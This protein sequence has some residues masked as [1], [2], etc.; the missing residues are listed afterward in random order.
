MPWPSSPTLSSTHS[1]NLAEFYVIGSGSGGSGTGQNR[2]SGGSNYT[3]TL[4][5]DAAYGSDAIGVYG[6]VFGANDAIE[7]GSTLTIPND[8]AYSL[9]IVFSRRS[10]PAAYGTLFQ[11][12]GTTPGMMLRAQV[13]DSGPNSA[14][15][16]HS[17]TF[18]AAYDIASS[19]VDVE[20][21]LVVTHTAG[22]TKLFYTG[23]GASVGLSDRW[24][25][26]G[27]I[28]S[29]FLGLDDALGSNFFPARFRA[30]G[31]WERALSDANA[32]AIA[33][34]PQAE[35]L[36]IP[37]P[38][39]PTGVTAG[40]I[41]AFGA[42]CSWTDASSDETSFDVQYA[43]SPY[44]SWTTASGSPTAANATS[45]AVTGLTDGTAYKFRVRA[46]N[47]NGSSVWVESG[48]FTTLAL[49]RL[50]PN[51]DTTVGSATS[52]GANLFGV[53]D[54]TT[55]DD[56]DYITIPGT[57]TSISLVQGHPSETNIKTWTPSPG[58]SF[59]TST[60]TMTSG[61]ASAITDYAALYVK[62]VTSSTT[63]KMKF[64]NATDPAND[65]DHALVIR[66]RAA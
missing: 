21:C 66:L 12:Y 6:E 13:D 8:Q 57:L 18:S 60:L 45:L 19:T 30:I 14:W 64:E 47:G 51:A 61:E 49:T 43:P 35:L 7:I 65:N 27:A 50:R 5:S 41:T 4:R 15:F 38:N 2:V 62:I 1:T 20:H 59:A 36:T 56:A 37:L 29:I 54:E 33:D 16:A 24:T 28:T 55:A 53:L 26:G 3:A 46:T 40:S 63:V 34:D 48:V 10:T 22:T 11:F 31:R 58:G 39:A 32:Q 42:T 52:T 25:A 23:G 9:V 44:T 17:N